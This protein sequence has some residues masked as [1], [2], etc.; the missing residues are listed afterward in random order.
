MK[1]RYNT[2]SR[3]T[4][5]VHIYDVGCT[6]AQR[7]EQKTA[8]HESFQFV[9]YSSSLSLTEQD[10]A[11]VKYSERC[12][13]VSAAEFLK[14]T[15]NGFTKS[16]HFSEK[17]L[18]SGQTHDASEDI[19][20]FQENLPDAKQESSCLASLLAIN[21][22]DH[23]EKYDDSVT[24]IL[25]TNK[26]GFEFD[27]LLSNLLQAKF[28]VP[29]LGIFTENVRMQNAKC[30][31]I[32]EEKAT[33]TIQN[34]TSSNILLKPKY[35]VALV[36]SKGTDNDAES[37]P[38]EDTIPWDLEQK[39][40]VIIANAQLVI[41]NNVIRKHQNIKHCISSI[42]DILAEEG[43]ILIH[44]VTT[45]FQIAACLDNIYCD[46]VTDYQD[47][48]DRTCSIYCNAPKWKNIFEEEGLE[49]IYEVSDNLL[50]SLFLL[51]R[52]VTNVTEKQTVIDVNDT[53]C[54]WVEDLKGRVEEVGNKAKG[55]NL[56]LR[57][58]SAK[59]GI[60]GLVTCLG[61]E[62]ENNKLR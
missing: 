11:L 36:D 50:S 26:T 60:L 56:W 22:V 43:F 47:L 52:K 20:A 32:S 25:K 51:R 4:G 61:R 55:E 15:N 59:S 14:A 49:V 31:E 16:R 40:P 2:N 30:V 19:I 1:L 46:N 13:S 12:L 7:V 34:L 28:L 29:A 45:N 53:D 6:L 62:L 23:N 27:I 8:T 9:P 58:D 38:P 57:A 48:D 35:Y 37:E 3:V 18:T 41:A 24:E 39:A 17:L 54:V 33:K 21:K 42:L 10:L 44:E 5:G